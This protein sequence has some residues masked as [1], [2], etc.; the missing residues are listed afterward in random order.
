LEKRL[1]L[2]REERLKMEHTMG[3]LESELSTALA[4][5]QELA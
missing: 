4:E 5:M 2:D 3:Y 1:E